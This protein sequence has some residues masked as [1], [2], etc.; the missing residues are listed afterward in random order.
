VLCRAILDHL[1]CGAIP[2][3]VPRFWR[4]RRIRNNKRKWPLESTLTE[5][6]RGAKLS[7]TSRPGHFDHELCFNAYGLA[8]VPPFIIDLMT[9]DEQLEKMSGDWDRRARE[10]ARYYVATSNRNW[11]DE[12]FFCSGEQ[13]LQDFIFSDM[14]N[15]CQGKD[16]KQMR[17]L[18]IGC[19]AGRM[20]RALANVFGEVHAVDISAEMVALCKTAVQPFPNVQV[21]QNNGKDLTVIP[22]TSFDFAFSVIVFQHIPSYRVIES[23]ISEVSRLLRP[24][25]LFKFQVQ[26]HGELET[27]P[28]DTWVGVGFSEEQMR[29]IA[30]RTHFEMRHFHGGGTQDFWLWFFRQ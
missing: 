26:G 13:S 9:L 27:A 24:G 14:S 2:A 29:G 20:T 4:A 1:R 25:C 3:E 19:G 28:G 16:P 15:I 6:R 12:E 18:E 22:E 11:S 7:A 17:V 21:Y 8:L 10:N 5:S 23:Y 30:E